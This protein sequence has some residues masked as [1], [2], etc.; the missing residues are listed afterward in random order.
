[1]KNKMLI[2]IVAITTLFG[3]KNQ[4]EEDNGQT[5]NKVDS[6]LLPDPRFGKEYYKVLI[7]P[8]AMT[9]DGKKVAEISTDLLVDHYVEKLD[10]FFDPRL[11]NEINAVKAKKGYFKKLLKE[12]FANTQGMNLDFIA[13]THSVMEMGQ[14]PPDVIWSQLQIK[15][16]L[17]SMHYDA[18]GWETSAIEDLTPALAMDE[19][20]RH[21]AM[22]GQDPSRIHDSDFYIRKP[23]EATDDAVQAK[24]FEDHSLPIVGSQDESL[25]WLDLQA[26]NLYRMQ[27]PMFAHTST[28]RGYI[29]VAKV[30][31]YMKKHH[32]KHGV[33]VLG[34]NHTVQAVYCAKGLGLKMRIWNTSEK[35]NFENLFR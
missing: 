16:I 32:C 7:N 26:R 17:D 9:F 21:V 31:H 27:T 11:V 30:L 34:M 24:W 23:D 19:T 10:S 15:T 33:L 18:I 25:W 5:T 14:L 4:T 3:C 35:E 1:M 6:A 22:M 2:A 29:A 13:Q 28:F 12:S 20:R 8:P